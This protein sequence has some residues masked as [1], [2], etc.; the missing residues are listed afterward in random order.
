[1]VEVV[2][3]ASFVDPYLVVVELVAIPVLEAVA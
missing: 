2:V 1:V 3:F